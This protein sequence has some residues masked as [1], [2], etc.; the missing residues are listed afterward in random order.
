MSNLRV[1]LCHFY[2][3]N[4]VLTFQIHGNFLPSLLEFNL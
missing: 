3:Q 2:Y 1:S 4:K